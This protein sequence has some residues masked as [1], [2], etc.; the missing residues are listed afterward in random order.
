MGKLG[1]KPALVA[2]EAHYLQEEVSMH[3]PEQECARKLQPV[4]TIHDYDLWQNQ[5]ELHPRHGSRLQ[6][7]SPAMRTGKRLY[8]AHNMCGGLNLAGAGLPAGDLT[9]SWCCLPA[10][11]NPG[12]GM[13]Q[14][15]HL[16]MAVGGPEKPPASW[17]DATAF[18]ETC[19]PGPNLP[20]L[21]MGPLQ[22][23]IPQ[24]THVRSLVKE[25]HGNRSGDVV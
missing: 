14:S 6:Q 19:V 25:L 15:E 12:I 17:N 23:T 5:E 22:S 3:A 9:T 11:V 2:S 13:G 21:M 7:T 4:L 10:F 8:V 24:A 18:W 20:P 1:G 16:V